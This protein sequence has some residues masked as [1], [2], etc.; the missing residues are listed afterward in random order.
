MRVFHQGSVSEG[1]R[2]CNARLTLF[3]S[4][5]MPSV[6]V[7]GPSQVASALTTLLSSSSVMNRINLNLDGVCDPLLFLE[8]LLPCTTQR[9]LLHLFRKRH[10]KPNVA[11]KATKPRTVCHR[12]FS[13]AKAWCVGL[14]RKKIIRIA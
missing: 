5:S 10:S 2:F 7:S 12:R 8:I 4:S 11:T 1:R 14:S 6:D 3:L 13:I 9:R